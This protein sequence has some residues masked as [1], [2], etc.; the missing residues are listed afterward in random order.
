MRTL[1]HRRACRGLIGSACGVAGYFTA[2]PIIKKFSKAK[3]ADNCTEQVEEENTEK[4]E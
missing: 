3:A 1:P 2:M 4:T